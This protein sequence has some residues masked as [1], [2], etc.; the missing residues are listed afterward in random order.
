MSNADEKAE[1]DANNQQNNEK[2]VSQDSLFQDSTKLIEYDEQINIKT[3]EELLLAKELLIQSL[4]LNSSGKSNKNDSLL[5]IVSGT[6]EE[7]KKGSQQ[8][9]MVE[10]WKSPIN[11]K[12]YQASKNKIICFGLSNIEEIKLFSI[13]NN[14]FL[15]YSETV[16]NIELTDDFNTY[17]KVSDLLL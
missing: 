3:E 6:K 5:A 8:K 2:N 11:Y 16:Y 17:E 7:V 9:I 14:L 1:N 10:L 13:K 15:K 12:G 4:E